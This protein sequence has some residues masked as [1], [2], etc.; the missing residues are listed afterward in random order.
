VQTFTFEGMPEGRGQRHGIRRARELRAARRT[1][2]YLSGARVPPPDCRCGCGDEPD[3]SPR[4]AWSACRGG[5]SAVRRDR[6]RHRA[7]DGGRGRS[8]GAR[9]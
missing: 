8:A 5:V 2:C 3:P 4:A 1:A 7:A 9:R 6:A